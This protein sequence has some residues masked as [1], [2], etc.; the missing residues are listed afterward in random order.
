VL[1]RYRLGRLLGVGGMGAVYEA[2]HR[3]L[4][5]RVA[6]KTLH[7]YLASEPH[8]QQ[9]FLQEGQAAARIHHV[10][11][12]EVHDVCIDGDQPY[13]VMELLEGEDLATCIEREGAQSVVRTADLLVPVIAAMAAAHDHGVLHR[14]LKPQNV[15]LCAH[16]AQLVPKVLDFGISKLSQPTSGIA[17]TETGYVLGTPH[18]MSPEQAQG[19][20]ELDARSD[21]YSLG[22]ILYETA[23]GLRP[24]HDVPPYALLY[25]TVLGDFPSPRQRVPALPSSFEALVLK[26]MAREPESRFST[27]RSLGLALLAYASERVRRDYAAELGMEVLALPAAGTG[28]ALVRASVQPLAETVSAVQPPTPARTLATLPPAVH[29]VSARRAWKW[30]PLVAAGLTACI[31]VF[32]W[33]VQQDEGVWRNPLASAAFKRLVDFDGV[34]QAA[35][36]SRDGRFVAFLSDGEGPMDVWLTQVGTGQFT[37]LTRGAFPELTNSMVRTLGFSPDGSLVT[38]WTRQPDGTGNGRISVWAVPLLG[39]QARPYLEGVSEYDWTKDGAHIVYHTQAAGDPTFVRDRDP[40]AGARHIFTAPAAGIHAHFQTW[41]AAQDFIYFVQGTLPD[42]MDIWRVRPTGGDAEQIT[43]HNS[44]VSYPV[45]WNSSTLLYLATDA[46]GSGPWLRGMDLERR[47]SHRIGQGLDRYTSLAASENAR[48]LVAT[49]ANPKETLWRIPIAE[50]PIPPAA[51]TRVSLGTGQ[52]SSPRLGPDYLLYVTS[53]GAGESIWKLHDGATTEL[54]SAPGVRK[55]AGP[56]IDRSGAWVTFAAEQGQRM[57]L[58]VMR[59][60]GTDVTLVS[61]SLE[62][63]GAPAWAPDGQSIVCAAME[64]ATPHLFQIFIDGRKPVR[65]VQNYAVDPVWDPDGRFVLYSG[66]DVGTRFPLEAVAPS[67]TAPVLPEL[68]LSRGAR[69]VCFLPG[70]HAVVVLR[71]EIDHKDLA[72]VDLDTGTERQLTNLGRDFEVRDFDVAPDGREVV[73]S[74]IQELSDVVLIEVPGDD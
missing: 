49:V 28:S 14:D 59:A 34:E 39:G 19:A 23:T 5:K 10:N 46:D 62:L 30:W 29:N 41:S 31:G 40:S 12:A 2:T 58:Y 73:L 4:G 63:R 32:I 48:R 20:A 22:V 43:H 42:A 71:G 27:T 15:F 66:A 9:R 18:Y 45:L 47:V 51:A 67:G 64:G 61:E 54:W 60:D 26:A 53:K 11:V 7:A 21:Q 6:I 13:L 33:R 16:R 38:F 65:L 1:G 52:G 69:R 8:A 25:R 55:I 50:V 3:D 44:R 36:L 70:R 17:P 74:R 56:A 57:R 24:L 72:L 68:S 35:A 37:N